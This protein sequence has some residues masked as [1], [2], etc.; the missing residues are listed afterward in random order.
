MLK[1]ILI[2]TT[3]DVGTPGPGFELG[4]GVLQIVP[5]LDTARAGNAIE[6]SVAHNAL[7]R[8]PVIVPATATVVRATIAWSDPPAS[9]L[10][11]TVLVNDV[12]LRLVD[13]SGRVFTPWVLDANNPANAAT[14]NYPDRLNNPKFQREN[15]G[16]GDGYTEKS[17]NAV[18][19]VSM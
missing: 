9:A 5:A 18:V 6:S 15:C 19:C 10:A 2:N 1:A 17:L 3:L 14:T 8:F 11:S 13:P 7:R 4:Y 12:D 16:I